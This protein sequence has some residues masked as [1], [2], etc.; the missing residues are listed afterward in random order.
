M[1]AAQH[2]AACTTAA[3]AA[4]ATLECVDVCG[5]T[6]V[7]HGR[8]LHIAAAIACSGT[9]SVHVLFCLRCVRA[10]C[11]R[12][13][14]LSA[15]RLQRQHLAAWMRVV[16][17]ACVRTSCCVNVCVQAGAVT[18][19]CALRACMSTAN[20]TYQHQIE[21]I[22]HCRCVTRKPPT[23]SPCWCCIAHAHVH[24]CGRINAVLHLPACLLT[25][26]SHLSV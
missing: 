13:L 2:Y 9:M 22:V 14:L 6:W 4:T 1:H 5:C 19:I 18:S 20:S 21:C 24:A 16:R 25:Q 17:A 11:M 8:Q 23:A 10:S 7:R 3:A 15:W 26:M 12:C